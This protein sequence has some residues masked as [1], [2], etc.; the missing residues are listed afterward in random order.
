MLERYGWSEELQRQFTT[1]AEPGLLP[2]RV[3]IQQRGLY[4][5]VCALGEMSAGL[6][7]RFMQ[8]AADG[9]FPVAG[10]W[11]AVAARPNEGRATIKQ[12]LPRSGVFRRRAAGPG[13]ATCASRRC[14][15]R[16]RSALGVVE[17]AIS[18]YAAWSAIWRPRGKAMPT[19]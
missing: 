9:D 10:D 16:H 4:V 2:A 19:R 3:I 7:G 15:C 14:Q 6:S 17:C 18:A 1:C 11:V 8:D 5:V 13:R 12:R